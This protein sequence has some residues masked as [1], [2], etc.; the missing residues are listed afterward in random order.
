MDLYKILEIKNN[1][2]QEE[3]RKS[4]KRLSLIHHPDRETGN[5][6]K[7]KEISSAYEILG[8]PE[9]R[10]QYDSKNDPTILFDNMFSNVFKG[11]FRNWTIIVP[12]VNCNIELSL[13]EVFVGAIRTIKFSRQKTCTDCLN[14][15]TNCDRCK[16]TRLVN[17]DREENINLPAGLVQNIS[18]VTEYIIPGLGNQ[19]NSQVGSLRIKIKVIPNQRYLQTPYGLT[20]QQDICITDV[21]LGNKFN[22]I[23]PNFENINVT[24]NCL[25]DINKLHRIKEK[26][27]PIKNTA[28][29]QDLYIKFNLVLPISLTESQKELLHKLRES[30]I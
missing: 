11:G 21:L 4:F 16:S 17:E 30:G 27:L 20:Y 2:S 19:V 22:I 25:T 18:G 8:N 6:D 26:G 9:K 1:A 13:E 28:K 3:V 12:D 14:R 7:F 24:V 10:K 23:L 29:R 5:E 15:N